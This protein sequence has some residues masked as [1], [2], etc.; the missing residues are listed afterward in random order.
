[1]L[2]NKKSTSTVASVVMGWGAVFAAVNQLIVHY[3]E[4]ILFLYCGMMAVIAGL[5]L[6]PLIIGEVRRTR[7]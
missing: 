4:K 3:V 2:G 6:V 7:E 5:L 1:M